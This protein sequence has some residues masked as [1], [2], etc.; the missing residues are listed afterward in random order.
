[1]AYFISMHSN[2]FGQ[3]T[4]PVLEFSEEQWNANTFTYAPST[5][6]VDSVG[7]DITDIRHLD[8]QQKFTPIND[9]LVRVQDGCE[10]LFNT[11]C[12]PIGLSL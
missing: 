5:Y 2:V 9:I 11:S 1:M 10:G 8:A 3:N 6:Y 7:L 12:K 4:N